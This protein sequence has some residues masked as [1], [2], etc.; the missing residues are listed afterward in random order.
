VPSTDT[1]L[2][3]KLQAEVPAIPKDERLTLQEVAQ[4]AGISPRAIERYV[5]RTWRNPPTLR[6]KTWRDETT[7]RRYTSREYLEEA[8]LLSPEGAPVRASAQSAAVPVIAV[9]ETPGEA[10]LMQVIRELQ[11]ENLRLRLRLAQLEANL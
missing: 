1:K 3:K 10:V 6:L 7:G 5:S 8:E 9:A 11:D 2:V 4:L